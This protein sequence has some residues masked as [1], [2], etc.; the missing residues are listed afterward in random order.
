MA[1]AGAVVAAA[2]AD[3]G[4]GEGGSRGG[5]FGVA[6]AAAAGAAAAVA[7]AAGAWPV[8]GARDGAA[9]GGVPWLSATSTPRCFGCTGDAVLCLMLAPLPWHLFVGDSSSLGVSEISLSR[10]VDLA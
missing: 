7:A 9:G 8:A 10:V 4:G 6:V 3:G 5:G 2:V 1:V